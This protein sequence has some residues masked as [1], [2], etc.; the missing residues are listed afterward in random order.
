MKIAV[1]PGDGIG[2]EI[3]AEAVKV[4]N[5]LALPLEMETALVGGVAYDAHGHPLPEATLKLAKEADA[6]LF[7][8]V[9]DWKYDA[10]ERNL[11]PEQAILG[12]RKTFGLFANFRTA[13][14]YSEL[15]NAS[16]LKPEIVAGLDILIIRELTGDIYFGQPRG[17]RVAPDG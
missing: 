10:L 16:S 1:L 9:G 8:A 11:R 6:V 5:T 17:R 13:I 15:A 2:T 7:G 3:V 14:L 4:L 12:L